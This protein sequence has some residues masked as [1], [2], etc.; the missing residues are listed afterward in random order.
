MQLSPL[1]AHAQ[2]NDTLYFD[3][4]FK[5]ISKDSAYAYFRVL[6]R[7]AKGHAIGWVYDYYNSGELQWKGHLLQTDTAE[8][9]DGTTTY[10]ELDGHV[11]T[12]EN[13]KNG[14]LNGITTTFYQSGKTYFKGYFKDGIM[15][16]PACFLNEN[17]T[18]KERLH[19]RYGKREGADTT[20]YEN[21]A[22]FELNY[23]KDD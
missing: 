23:Y 8:V 14:K 21:G 7:D 16:E 17:G 15:Q 19:L 9:Q 2:K 20:F 3:A 13:Y 12:I 1:N 5:P 6:Q 22:V 18:L 11:T 10:Y 4:H